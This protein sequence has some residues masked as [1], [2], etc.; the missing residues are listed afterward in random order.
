[1][2]DESCLLFFQSLR[3][4]LCIGGKVDGSG[5]D[6]RA[7]D[8]VVEE[9]KAAGGEAT[10]NY[11]SVENGD[12]IVKTAMVSAVGASEGD[13]MFGICAE[14]IR[15]PYSYAEDDFLRQFGTWLALKAPSLPPPS[16]PP[17]PFYAFHHFS[18]YR[19]PGVVWTSSSTMPAFCAT[20]PS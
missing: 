13:T 14:R 9:I 7:A 20:V 19:I 15:D 5:A 2:L 6:A 8:K 3:H 17:R 16:L 12:K 1:M 10:P 18:P 11:D 4:S